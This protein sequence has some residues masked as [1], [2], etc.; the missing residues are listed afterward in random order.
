MGGNVAK[1]KITIY[2]EDVCRDCIFYLCRCSG[3]SSESIRCWRQGS[4]W[5][6]RG[7]HFP[8]LPRPLPRSVQSYWFNRAGL[9]RHLGG[10]TVQRPPPRQRLPTNNLTITNCH[11][12]NRKA[13]VIDSDRSDFSVRRGTENCSGLSK[14]DQR[15]SRRTGVSAPRGQSWPDTDSRSPSTLLR[16][17]LSTALPRIYKPAQ[18]SNSSLAVV[19][20]PPVSVPAP[21]ER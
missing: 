5:S 16:G 1:F 11:P 9:S 3:S 8:L 17:G 10:K 21:M 19:R 4:L 12:G 20:R 2:K 14:K 13:S 7:Q 6:I 15:Q 18:I